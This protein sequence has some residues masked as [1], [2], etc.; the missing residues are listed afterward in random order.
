MTRERDESGLDFEPKKP[1]A[2]RGRKPKVKSEYTDFT[3]R[4]L[5]IKKIDEKNRLGRQIQGV[6][7]IKKANGKEI[8]RPYSCTVAIFDRIWKNKEAPMKPEDMKN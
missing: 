2:K 3:G 6:V 8:T 5:V 1:K 7:T 4:K